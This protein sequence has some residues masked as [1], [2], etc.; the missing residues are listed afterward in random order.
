MIYSESSLDERILINSLVAREK[1]TK[2]TPD[3]R[4]WPPGREKAKVEAVNG[5]RPVMGEGNADGLNQGK[6][7]LEPLFIPMLTIAIFVSGEQYSNGI[8]QFT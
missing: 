3:E 6:V 2:Q 8:S 5:K 1:R 7:A 4:G